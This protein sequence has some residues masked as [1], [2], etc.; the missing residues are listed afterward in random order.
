MVE[1]NLKR[2]IVFF[3]VE[4]TGLN[5]IRDRIVQIALI[6][7]FKNGNEPQEF[8]ALINPGIPMSE[9]SISIHGLTPDILK[10]KPTFPQLG[11][12][13]F[14]FI[15]DADLAGYNSDRF[16][17]PILMEE[18]ARIGL[19]FRI[20]NRHL[21]DVQK[22]FYKM[23]P[24]TLKA[25][26]ALYCGKELEDAH[27]A[28][29]DVRATVDVF[30]GQLA[31]YDGKDYIDGDGFVTPAPIVNDI[32][33]ISEFLSDHSM[34][35][36][37]QRLRYDHNGEIVFNFGKYIGK[38]VAKTLHEDKQYYQWI[39]EKE[40]SAQMKQIVRDIVSK[41]EKELKQNLNDKK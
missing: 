2:D 30:K 4:S 28:L 7:Y 14:D 17:V 1:L 36:V 34:L 31:K 41:F 25:A 21:I 32:P 10:N 33:K 18:F 6:K 11:K 37:T 27:D 29:S 15:G 20:D 8:E 40:F 24:R 26:L 22:I 38:S 13:I 35:D 23:E 39:Q 19:D 5:V 16:D 12:K 3:D 9:E